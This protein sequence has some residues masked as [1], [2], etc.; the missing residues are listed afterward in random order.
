MHN[1]DEML[2]DI[3]LELIELRQEN[4]KLRE[5]NKSLKEEIKKLVTIQHQTKTGR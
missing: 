2:R 3:L 1:Q 4:K 5:E